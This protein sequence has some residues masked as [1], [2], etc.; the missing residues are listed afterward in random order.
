ML[1]PARVTNVCRRPE[2]VVLAIQY[3]EGEDAISFV[4]ISKGDRNFD[5]ADVMTVGDE[6]LASPCEG[7][8]VYR[9]RRSYWLIQRLYVL[10]FKRLIFKIKPLFYPL[11]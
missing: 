3:Y 10:L 9:F 2:K 4:E 11:L 7:N 5:R 6:V 1:L 8:K